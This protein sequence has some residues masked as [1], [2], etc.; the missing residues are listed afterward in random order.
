M[1]AHLPRVEGV[2]KPSTMVGGFCYGWGE[3]FV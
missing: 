2:T 3:I 1:I